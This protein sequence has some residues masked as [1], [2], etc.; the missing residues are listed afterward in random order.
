MSRA[1]VRRVPA[2]GHTL[3]RPDVIAAEVIG[4]VELNL[5][6]VGLLKNPLSLKWWAK[7]TGTGN[8]FSRALPKLS[9]SRVFA[10]FM[11][12]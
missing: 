6:T 7:T 11:D 10:N 3:D 5:G 4:F 8:S 1:T 9:Q 2:C 12:I